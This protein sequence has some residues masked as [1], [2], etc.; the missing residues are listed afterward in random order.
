VSSGGETSQTL[1]RGLT[2]LALLAKHSDGLTAAELAGHIGAAR[3]IVYRLLRTLEAH[4]LVTRLDTRY[5]LG[6]GLAELAS[7]LRPRLQSVALPILQQLSQRT[8]ST[9]LL[10]VADGDQALVLLTAEPPESTMHLAMREGARH[11]L[12]VGADGV[13]ILAGR[14]PSSSDTE[15]VLRARRQGYAIS[16]GALQEGAVGVAAPIRVSDWPTASLGIVR[17]GANAP[18]P[19]VADL[20]TSAAA[21]AAQRL[22]GAPGFDRSNGH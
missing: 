22:T 1:D 3:A 11:P 10:S 15:D 12:A 17:I 6:F 2:V 13:A 7:R 20:V 21:Q 19:T 18:D 5:V 16:V 8:N 9:A 14:P 4:N